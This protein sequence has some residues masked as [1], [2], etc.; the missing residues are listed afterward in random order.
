MVR[1]VA[2]FQ[3]LLELCELNTCSSSVDLVPISHLFQLTNVTWL[4]VELGPCP[5]LLSAP[6]RFQGAPGGLT[7]ARTWKLGANVQ[8]QFL[9]DQFRTPERLEPDPA[10]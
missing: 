4:V 1:M 8:S 7:D 6:C 9:P 3:G 2:F 10:A 5:A